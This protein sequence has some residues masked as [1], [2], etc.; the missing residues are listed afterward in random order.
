MKFKLIRDSNCITLGVLTTRYSR[1]IDA[2]SLIYKFHDSL[3]YLYINYGV[4]LGF[5]YCRLKDGDGNGLRLYIKGEFTPPQR[6][7]IAF[8]DIIIPT[9]LRELRE[10]IKL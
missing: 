10:N 3:K 8:K 2:I 6:F 4:P 5:N 1:D 9:Y 7:K